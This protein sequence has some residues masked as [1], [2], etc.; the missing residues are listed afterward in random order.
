MKCDQSQ[1]CYNTCEEPKCEW[2]CRSPD[3]CPEPKCKLQCETPKP[4]LGF[5]IHQTMPP[6]QCGEFEV[7][8]FKVPNAPSLLSIDA[9]THAAGSHATS[10]QVH[11]PHML[12]VSVTFASQ[13][14]DGSPSLAKLSSQFVQIPAVF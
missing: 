8:H 9:V 13:S 3:V 12:N 11:A 4:C 6:L 10:E 14:T 7:F 1:N 5:G 2:K